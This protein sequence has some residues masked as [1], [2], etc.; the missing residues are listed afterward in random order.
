MSKNGR[1]RMNFKER[2]AER[3][4]KALAMEEKHLKMTDEKIK[5]TAK[6]F[7]LLNGFKMWIQMKRL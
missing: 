7:R 5:Q 3:R 6:R 1:T 4:K 2:I